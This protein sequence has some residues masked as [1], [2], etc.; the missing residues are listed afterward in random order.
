MTPREIYTTIYQIMKCRLRIVNPTMTQDR[1]SRI[2]NKF[3]VKHT[4]EFYTEPS[5]LNEFTNRNNT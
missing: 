5:K 3:A 2:A 4:W 1:A